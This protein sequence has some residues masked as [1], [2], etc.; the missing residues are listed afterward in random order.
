MTLLTP[1]TRYENEIVSP[2]PLARELHLKP[3][4]RTVKNRFLKS[5][6]AEALATWNPTTIEERGIPTDELVELYGK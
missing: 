5:P 2:E 4:G 6:M 3:S 1:P